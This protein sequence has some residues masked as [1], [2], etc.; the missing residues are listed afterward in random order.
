[1]N[2]C[3][4]VLGIVLICSFLIFSLSLFLFVLAARLL[5]FYILI[6]S[7]YMSYIFQIIPK[8]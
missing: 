5:S 3:E 4:Y 7:V 1:M 2:V 6:S 8:V